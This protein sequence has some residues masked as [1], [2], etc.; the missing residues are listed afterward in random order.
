MDRREFIKKTSAA[1]AALAAT[2]VTAQSAESPN[3]GKP[4]I[5]FIL[6]DEMRFPRVFPDGITDVGGFLKTYMPNTYDLWRKGVKFSGHYTAAS[7]CSPARAAL[8]TGLYTQ[9][10]W[11]L[12]TILDSP[13]TQLSIQPVLNRQFPTYGKILKSLGYSTPYIG[14]WHL[15]IVHKGER[16]LSLYGFEGMT[17]PDPTGSNLQG[18]IGDPGEGYLSDT[19]IAAQA[20]RYLQQRKPGDVPWCL[21]VGFIN[22]HDKEFFPAGTEFKRFTALFNSSRYN[23]NGYTQWIDYTAGPPAYNW[24]FNPLRNPPP[25]GYPSTAPNWE[26]GS[27]LSANKPPMQ[28]FNRTIQEAVWG[29]VQDS[30]DAGYEI[31]AYPTNPDFPPPAETKGIAKAPFH[32]WKRGLDS[33]TQI[34]S[35]VDERIGE[36]V[37]ALPPDVAKKTIVVLT[38][39]HGD[40]AGAHGLISGKTGTCYEEAFNVPLIVVDPTGQYNGDL[41]TVRGGLTSSVDLVPMFATIGNGGQRSWMTGDYAQLYGNRHDLM[42]MLKSSTAPG[43]PYVVF[44]SDETVPEAL[45]FNQSA[46]HIIGVR[47]EQGKL[48]T[49]SHW[50][51]Q[52]T[53]ITGKSD[54]EYYDYATERGQLELENRYRTPAARALHRQLIQDI[55]PN[56]LQAP[57]PGNLVAA[58]NTAQSRYL[59][60]VQLI[61]SGGNFELPF[62]IGD[63]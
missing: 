61:N 6:L 9:Q 34:M 7:A 53:T 59:E 4:N 58:Q 26:S 47:T 15:S 32:Y 17:Y 29:G 40:Y 41:D 39:D 3:A 44:S 60:Y 38:S 62:K 57:L 18:T 23:P 13:D 45:N 54:L 52:T 63:I 14:K 8:V 46:S 21:T 31:S 25:L 20:T 1:G 19:N 2:H 37:N 16:P 50:A 51:P 43:R 36:V 10:N 27:Q 49:Y 42:P 30:R 11:L 33:Y 24:E 35:I 22:P 5:L 56:E 55:L 48:G 12:T 28:T